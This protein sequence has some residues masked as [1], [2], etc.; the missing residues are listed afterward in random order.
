MTLWMLWSILFAAIVGIAALAVER[1]AA[2]FGAP[3][4]HIWMTAL[5]VS[6]FVPALLAIRR[7]EVTVVQAAAPSPV[8]PAVQDFDAPTTGSSGAI[9]PAPPVARPP[10]PRAHVTPSVITID[11]LTL[12]LWIASSLTMAGVFG[13]SILQ[14]HRQRGAWTDA[15]VADTRVLLSSD[16]GPA[17]IGFTHPAIVFP[18]WALTLDRR[19]QEMM[20]RHESEHIRAGDP[21]MLLIA[22]L[23]IIALPWHAGVWWLAR[24]LRMAMELDCDARVIRS[25]GASREYGL[26]LLAVGERHTSMFPL[27]SSLASPRPLLERRIDAMSLPRPRRPLRAAL[28]FIAVAM[29]ATTAASRAPRPESLRAPI[30]KL[31]Q[32]ATVAPPKQSAPAAPAPQP[33]PAKVTRTAT[34]EPPPPARSRATQPMAVAPTTPP[35]LA[36]ATVPEAREAP[37]A[38]PA[39][40]QN[41]D[42]AKIAAFVKQYQQAVVRGDSAAEY[43]VMVFDASDR[44]VWSTSGRGNVSIEIAGDSRTP[45]ERTAHNRAHRAEYMGTMGGGG[46]GRGRGGASGGGATDTAAMRQLVAVAGIINVSLD[47]LGRLTSSSGGGRGAAAAAG[48]GG[49]RARGGGAGVQ[50]RDSQR[51]A[52]D[53]NRL[54]LVGARFGDSMRLIVRDSLRQ[55]IPITGGGVA[56]GGGGGGRGS[57]APDTL[58]GPYRVGVISSRNASTSNEAPGLQELRP[59]E[60][61]IQGL[62]SK[63]IAMGET[64]RFAAGELAPHALNIHVVHLVAGA[65][66]KGRD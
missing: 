20:L 27:A 29:G 45:M 1:A 55:T 41:P 13:R 66:W 12:L 60:S 56:R 64:Y 38:V 49:G 61:G 7:T 63:S 43:I 40:R 65:G 24:R 34:P 28:P 6:A 31:Q 54:T 57:A 48:G 10:V 16:E 46:G 58:P 62:L 39:P 21:R 47:S 33:T 23:I 4:R 9:A 50:A 15:T 3:R 19:A 42:R 51:V 30:V 11:R 52:V 18:R 2:G 53:S 14:L 44:Y 5:V 8:Q 22:C 26:M 17:V 36:I 37:I 32:A 35:A 59:G 25:V